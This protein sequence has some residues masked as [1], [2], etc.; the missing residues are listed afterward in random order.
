MSILLTGASGFIAGKIWELLVENNYHVIPIDNRPIYNDKTDDSVLNI[1]IRD[2]DAL[3][4]L[5]RKSN[6]SMIC[7]QAAEISVTDSMKNP[8]FY[9]NV[10]VTGSVNLLEMCRKYNVPMVYASSCA[11]RNHLSSPYA[12]TKWTV[13]QYADMYNNLYNVK[14]MGLRYTNVYGEGQ[15]SYNVIP[16]FERRVKKG[17]PMTIYGDGKQTR[18]FIHVTDIA[19]ANFA[20]ITNSNSLDGAQVEEIGTGIETSI[21]DIAQ[22]VGQ[23]RVPIQYAPPRPGDLLY[24][25]LGHDGTIRSIDFTPEKR[26]IM[27]NYKPI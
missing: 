9:H 8:M 14:T 10:N 11:A 15:T 23:N 12:F 18:D 27:Q 17:I 5:F 22:L 20:A 26:D 19:R 6:I 21:N 13:E 1:D 16:I 25:K 4:D 24:T 7:H 2:I 3:D